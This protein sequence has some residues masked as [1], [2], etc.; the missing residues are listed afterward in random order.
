[1]DV[2]DD[3]LMEDWESS[4]DDD[5]EDQHFSGDVSSIIPNIASIGTDVTTITLPARRSVVFDSANGLEAGDLS[6]Y[7]RPAVK[8]YQS[9][10]VILKPNVMFQVTSSKEHHCKQ[11]GLYDVLKLLNN[12]AA[13]ALIFVLPPDRFLSF[14]YQKYHNTKGEAVEQSKYHNVRKIRQFAMKVKIDR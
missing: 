11:A 8:N 14:G 6:S 12:P 10:D 7:L 1:M 9:V 3:V 13:P 5:D 4:G 2:G